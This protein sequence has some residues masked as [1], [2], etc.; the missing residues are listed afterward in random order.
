M[1][2]LADNIALF[3]ENRDVDKLGNTVSVLIFASRFYRHGKSYIRFPSVGRLHLFRIPGNPAVKCCCNHNFFS[4]LKTGFH[5][6]LKAV[7]PEEFPQFYFASVQLD[8]L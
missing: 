3:A 2:I 7:L 1:K 4:F 6:F 8:S 5:L